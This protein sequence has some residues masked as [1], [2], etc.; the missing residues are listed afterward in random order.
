MRRWSRGRA[1]R[2]PGRRGRGRWGGE[3]DGGG[4]GA[5]AGST[6]STKGAEVLGPVH[7]A[8]GSCRGA[9]ADRR[10][11]GVLDVGAMPGR[12]EPAGHHGLRSGIAVGDVL[13]PRPTRVPA[14][15]EPLADAASD[16]RSRVA[17]LH[18][19]V[20]RH[21]PCLP[22]GGARQR[23]GHLQSD[24]PELAAMLVHELDDACGGAHIGARPV[25]GAASSPRQRP[26]RSARQ[27]RSPRAW[28]EEREGESQMPQP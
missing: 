21:V 23:A 4:A 15:L 20:V 12:G 7:R 16:R 8:A 2:R 6:R 9:D 24:E 22:V 3:G 17:V 18:V 19:A 13:A 27:R 26:R 5:E 14:R 25:R 11:G 10:E 1:C 28:K